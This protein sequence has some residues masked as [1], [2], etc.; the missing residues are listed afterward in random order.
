MLECV[1]GFL[2]VCASDSTLHPCISGEVNNGLGAW[3]F[4]IHLEKASD[5]VGSWHHSGQTMSAV[6]LESE[7]L[8]VSFCV[9]WFFK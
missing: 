8:S 4:Y 5:I 9:A 1:F 7:L 2:L 3:A 6:T